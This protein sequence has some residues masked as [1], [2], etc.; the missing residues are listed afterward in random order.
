VQSNL[1]FCWRRGSELNR[2]I[3]V[4][5]TFAY[6]IVGILYQWLEG[7]GTF[8][9]PPGTHVVWEQF[10]VAVAVAGPLARPNVPPARVAGP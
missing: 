7:N 8:V 10:I 6:Q 2:R 4:L 9:D 3:K 1:V 5:R